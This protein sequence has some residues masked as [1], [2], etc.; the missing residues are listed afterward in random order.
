[1]YRVNRTRGV[2]MAYVIIGMPVFIGF[3]GLAIDVARMQLGKTEAQAVAD[4]AARYA[5]LGLA[6]SHT[7]FPRHDG[8]LAMER[9]HRHVHHEP[10]RK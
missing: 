6:T 9:Q 8:R 3:C 2:A 5:A 7:P 4:A 1:M 10:V